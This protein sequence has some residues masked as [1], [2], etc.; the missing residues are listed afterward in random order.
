MQQKDVVVFRGTKEG[1]AV[2]LNDGVEFGQ[3]ARRLQEKLQSSRAFFQGAIVTVHTGNR[4][5]TPAQRAELE[6]L[7]GAES[8]LLLRA[9]V[10]D[11][12]PLAPTAP[13]PRSAADVETL[14]VRRT[15]RGGQ[16]VRHD[17]SVVV[18]GD[19][20]PGAEVVATGHIV[21]MGALRGVAH[22]GAAGDGSAVVVAVT[23]RPTQLRIAGAVARPPDNDGQA[24]GA[25]QPEVARLQDGA[26]IIEASHGLR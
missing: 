8:G 5:L 19:V 21:V 9:V 2:V 23:L 17:G 3:V 7:L 25:G 16:E 15:L 1:L 4:Q 13:A 11:H 22:A 14:V 18:L 24:A 12:T 6:S 26:I 10:A 20:N